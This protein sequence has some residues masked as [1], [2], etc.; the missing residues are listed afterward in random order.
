MGNKRIFITLR[1]L[2]QI[3]QLFK[4]LKI[5]EYYIFKKLKIF[6]YYILK[7]M[8]FVKVD[9]AGYFEIKNGYLQVGAP[10]NWIQK[11]ID[12]DGEEW[13]NNSGESVSLSNDGNTLA[14]GAKGNSGNGSFSGHVRVY[15]YDIKNGWTQKGIDIDGEAAIDTSGWSVSLSN[16]GNTLAIG[17]TGNDGN[18]DN[19]GHVRVY[20]YI[21][22][23]WTQKGIDIDGEAANDYS[24]NSVSLSNDGNTVAIG[25]RGND[26]NGNHS[27]HV[28]V[29]EYDGN[30]WIQKGIDIDGEAALDYSGNSV[31]LSNDGNTVAI[32]A[33]L[34]DGNGDR[35]G[36]VRVYEYINNTWTQKGID[37]DG[38]AA[39]DGSGWSVSL[40][41][42]GNTVAIGARVNAD[43]GVGSGHV[44]VYKYDI[45]NGW[46]QK[47]IDIDG[48]AALDYSGWSVSL[49]N[50]GNTVAI[51]AYSNDDHGFDNGHV[52]VY[53]FK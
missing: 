22:N 48:E 20:E 15:K 17:A 5:F 12:I 30:G 37:I 28:R 46:T 21:N 29:Y 42:D 32:G 34:N 38:E 31:S 10:P 41:N 52:R 35:S 6:A 50:D 2:F 51:G 36:H 19:S 33:I 26:G 40:S 11:G 1:G 9:G 14:I 13:Y 27:G 7:K 44:R 45:K 18:G 3:K 49:R 4:K 24:G 23:T 47:G 16:D 25:A 43:N 53:E 8:N 39:N